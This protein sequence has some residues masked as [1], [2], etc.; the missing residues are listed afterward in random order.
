ML[1]T[2]DALSNAFNLLASVV[3]DFCSR[4]RRALGAALKPELFR[5]YGLTEYQLG[6]PKFGDFLRA[7]ERAGFVRMVSTP[8]GDLEVWPPNAEP[9]PN[10][11]RIFLD[12]APQPVAS[13]APPW[14]AAARDD[15]PV[16]VRVDLWNAFT[17]FSARW[18]Y[19]PARDSA[20]RVQINDSESVGGAQL[21][22]IPSGRDRTIEWMRSFAEMQ[23]PET[24]SRLL[25]T[26]DG[27]QTSPY[28][29]TSSVR[30]DPKVFKSWH[31]YHVRQ[32]VAAIET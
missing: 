22:Q 29:F 13:V 15:A 12:T 27:G 3:R 32:V 8:G 5:R 24:R 6:F 25:T 1:S 21:I 20:F 18:V 2:N 11:Q 10:Q 7:A 28:Q 9:Q 23:D 14:S 19:D 26:L 17:S 30:S 4:G 16:R 31:R